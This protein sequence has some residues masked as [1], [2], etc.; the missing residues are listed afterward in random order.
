WRSAE[1]ALQQKLGV[2]PERP[3]GTG[4]SCGHHTR[5][6]R[7]A[8]RAVAPEIVQQ[9]WSF[10]KQF[11]KG[12]LSAV[13]VRTPSN[14]DL[15]RRTERNTTDVNSLRH[16]SALPDSLPHGCGCESRVERAARPA[17]VFSHRSRSDDEL[18]SDDSAR[19]QPRMCGQ[20]HERIRVRRNSGCGRIE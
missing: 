9:R 16:V 8:L 10:V 17:K 19:G 2:L 7:P 18:C 14:N 12:S 20:A 5:D 3:A 1:L 11:S 13:S 4:S 15:K 6:N